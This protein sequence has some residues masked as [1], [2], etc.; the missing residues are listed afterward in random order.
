MNELAVK[1]LKM[2]LDFMSQ[3]IDKLKAEL[4]AYAKAEEAEKSSDQ[5]GLTSINIE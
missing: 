1:L 5:R 3:V 2:K 4:E